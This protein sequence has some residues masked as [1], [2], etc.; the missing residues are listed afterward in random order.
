MDYQYD[1]RADGERH[2]CLSW[3]ENDQII[4]RCQQ[5]DFVRKIDLRTGRLSVVRVGDSKA[6]HRGAHRPFV[7][8]PPETDER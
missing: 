6:L 4:F 8:S 5:C 7:V 1:L 2:E 3:A